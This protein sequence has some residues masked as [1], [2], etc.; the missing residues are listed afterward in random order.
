MKQDNW[1]NSCLNKRKEQA[2]D[3]KSVTCSI[4]EE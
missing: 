1:E 2:T 4:K 3:M